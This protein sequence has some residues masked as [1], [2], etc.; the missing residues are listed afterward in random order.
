MEKVNF[1]LE[2]LE[3]PEV[4]RLESVYKLLLVAS[5]IHPRR[6]ACGVIT[7]TST[8]LK[9][10]GVDRAV[11]NGVVKVLED[12]QL[13]A[14]SQETL[15]FYVRGQFLWNKTPQEAGADSPWARQV[16]QS[17]RIVA[18]ERVADAIR[19]DIE[20]AAATIKEPFCS[21]PANL[22]TSIQVKGIDQKWTS[23][24][25][26]LLVVCYSFSLGAAPGVFVADFE[27]LGDLCSLPAAN[28]SASLVIL[29]K[30]GALAFDQ[31]TCE[32]VLTSRVKT[33]AAKEIKALYE[34]AT[35]M[36]SRRLKQALNSCLKK[37]FPKKQVKSTDYVLE[38]IRGY[39]R[40]RRVD[41]TGKPGLSRNAAGSS[42]KDKTQTQ[43]Q[44]QT[45]TPGSAEPTCPSGALWASSEDWLEALR[46]EGARRKGADLERDRR[47]ISK[48][49]AVIDELGLEQVLEAA[50][51]ASLPS[52]VEKAC[53]EAGLFDAAEVASKKR[54]AE[55]NEA[56]GNAQKDELFKNSHKTQGFDMGIAAK[57]GAAYNIRHGKVGAA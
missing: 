18:D 30:C 50:A 55:E 53:K 29:D 11:C 19:E 31:E 4:E 3:R 16:E 15:E 36:R 41:N 34:A 21:V 24:E 6:K 40:D 14:F 56:V 5:I 27:L 44:T 12:L 17:L 1:P 26:M 51:G 45:K 13:A 38:D 57:G 52:Q 22:L 47:T 48:I 39:E 23:G 25:L 43:T 33:A 10:V 32:V 42:D 46:A 28:V 7:L 35:G 54:R 9:S 8:V 37:S 2:Y 49:R 20:A